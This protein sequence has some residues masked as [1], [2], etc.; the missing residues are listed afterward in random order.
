MN[1]ARN[2][3][4][5]FLLEYHTVRPT[6]T[7]LKKMICLCFFQFFPIGTGGDATCHL[8]FSVKQNGQMASIPATDAA[9]LSHVLVQG[10]EEGE[11]A[12]LLPSQQ[13]LCTSWWMADGFWKSCAIKGCSYKLKL[14]LTATK[15]WQQSLQS[16]Q[17]KTDV[18]FLK[19]ETLYIYMIY[20]Y[21]FIISY[22]YIDR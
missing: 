8:Q 14:L 11:F 5:K 20:I 22:L 19:K 10:T 7:V 21:L 2:T 4:S 3:R 13:W 12:T 17:Y 16:I 15:T 9:F 1:F 6:L 18:V